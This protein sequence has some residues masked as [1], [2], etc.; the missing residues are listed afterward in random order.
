MMYNYRIDLQLDWLEWAV[1]HD[2]S[3]QVISMILNITMMMIM[4]IGDLDDPEY[5][6]DDRSLG[7]LRAPSSSWRPFGPLDFVLHALNAT[8]QS[9]YVG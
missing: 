8:K 3:D 1:S 9:V 4:M 6:D 7:A 2:R 5:Y